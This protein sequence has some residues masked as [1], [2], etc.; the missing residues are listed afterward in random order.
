M[1]KLV[2][3]G[4]EYLISSDAWDAWKDAAEPFELPDDVLRRVLGVSTTTVA[5]VKRAAARSSAAPAPGANARTTRSSRSGRRGAKS[6]QK[7]SR[8]SSDLLLPEG[9]YELP[10]LAA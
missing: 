1:P 2:A 3:D 10:I 7:R 9:E 5:L 6:G 4:R 8:V